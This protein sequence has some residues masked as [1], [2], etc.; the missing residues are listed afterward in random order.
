M[1]ASTA[2][3]RPAEMSSCATSAAHD[4]MNA[5]PTIASPKSAAWSGRRDV[6]RR[7]PE[8]DRG[9]GRRHR[10]HDGQPLTRW[11]GVGEIV[12]E[13]QRSCLQRLAEG[14]VPAAAEGRRAAVRD[15]ADGGPLSDYSPSK[16]SR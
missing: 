13:R 3:A 15:R 1:S 12:L 6:G 5:A 2:I 16:R 4:R 9:D 11:M 8:D 7:D 10:E 14:L